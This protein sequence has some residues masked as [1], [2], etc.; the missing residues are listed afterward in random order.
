MFHITQ[1]LGKF[2]FQQIWEGDV[3]HILIKGHLPTP[4]LQMFF[5]DDS[6]VFLSPMILQY[7]AC[8]L[9]KCWNISFWRCPVFSDESIL[10]TYT[11]KLYQVSRGS[12]E[13]SL[14]S[15]WLHRI[16]NWWFYQGEPNVK[17][18]LF[19]DIWW[20]NQRSNISFSHHLCISIEWAHIHCVSFYSYINIYMDIYIYIYI[21]IYMSYMSKSISMHMCLPYMPTMP[22]N[23]RQVRRRWPPDGWSVPLGDIWFGDLKQWT[24]LSSLGIWCLYFCVFY[25][26]M[27][28]HWF[29]HVYV[30]IYMGVHLFNHIY[31][32][33]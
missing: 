22:W 11:P 32:D 19:P 28:V 2:H 5:F 8:V 14:F 12:V 20:W 30:Y 26:Y 1:P 7:I 18:R 25:V 6:S 21:Y 27:F 9:K 33:R 16:S 31:I 17:Q 4:V 13:S 10:E 24:L 15:R 23:D 29:T 3:K